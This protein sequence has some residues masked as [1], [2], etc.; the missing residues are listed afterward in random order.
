MPTATVQCSY[1][2]GVPRALGRI[3]AHGA[4]AGEPAASRRARRPQIDCWDRYV[5]TA[6]AQHVVMVAHSFG[7]VCTV[8]LLEE[9]EQA[10]LAKLRAVAF[11]DSVHG[12][13]MVSVRS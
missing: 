11:T 10:V 12:G 1:I 3:D 5:T 6:A 7:G 2:A 13:R 4:R 9:R 8:T